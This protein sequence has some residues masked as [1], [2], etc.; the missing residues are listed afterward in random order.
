MSQ[1][2]IDLDIANKKESFSFNRVAAQANGSVW[3]TQGDAVLIATVVVDTNPVDE[4]FLPLMVQYIEKSY[5]AAKFPGGFIKRESKPSDF[6]TL[7]GRIVDRSLRPLFPKG[8]NYPVTIT[9]M[10]VSSDSNVDM[11][12]AAITAANAALMISGLGINE[13][14]SALRIG[15]IEN[16]IITNPSLDEQS[17]S[18]LDLL[19]V[20]K[21]DEIIM[22]EMRSLY[23]DNVNEDELGDLI[24]HSNDMISKT[25][26][27]YEKSF[28]NFKKEFID[29]PLNNNED[30]ELIQYVLSNYTKDIQDAI[31][32]MAKSER[33]DALDKLVITLQQSLSDSGIHKENKEIKNAISKCK[34][35]IFRSMVLNERKRADGRELNEVRN[36]TIETNILPSVHGSCLFTRGQTQALATVTLGNSKDA[37]SYELITEKQS[38]NENFMVHYNFPGFSVGDTKPIGPTNRRELGH[39]NLAKRALEPM[40]NRDNSQTIRVVSEILESNGSS[41]M[42]TVCGGSMALTA[43]G[44]KLDNLVAGVAMGLVCEND[45]YAVLTDIM[46]LEDF[47]GD[48]DFKIAGTKNGV[49]AMQMD[50]KLNGVNAKILKEAI[51]ES[52]SAKEHI[53]SL[54]N[55]ATTKIIASN[56]TPKI[57]EFAVH[58]SKIVDVIGK[59]GSII[60]DIIERFEVAIDLDRDNG[61][62]KLSGKDSLKLEAAKEHIIS[63]TNTPIKEAMQF[64]PNKSYIGKVKRIVDFGIF[65]EMPD[66]FDALLHNSKMDKIKQEDWATKYTVGDEIEVIVMEQNGKKIDLATPE[67]IA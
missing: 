20:G 6:E 43:A 49:T 59:A 48:M 30:S 54:L 62:V 52:K 56:A 34:T 27:E 57:V 63:I 32:H 2:K 58:P 21:K 60:R 19:V 17:N 42:A 29:L 3:Y 41:S 64:E 55:E 13:S 23:K 9:V 11:Q 50:I 33:S 10:V 26:T 39:G 8:F 36:I 12:V 45:K 7:T 61:G 24:E 25:C 47:E 1:A 37:Q 53:L 22:I 18:T 66:G 67:F 46:G 14:V 40:V 16:T 38:L 5:A 15:K 51:K 28:A 31:T 65:V 35:K 44:V 4:D